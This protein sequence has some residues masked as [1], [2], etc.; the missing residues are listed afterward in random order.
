MPQEESD[1]KVC[2]FCQASRVE[3]RRCGQWTAV[4]EENPRHSETL[5]EYQCIQCAR[6]FW[7]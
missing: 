6:A 4:S 2:P 3:L 5:E 1:P 7:V